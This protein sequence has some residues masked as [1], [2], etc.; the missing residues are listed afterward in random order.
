MNPALYPLPHA[1]RQREIYQN[2]YLEIF[3]YTAFTLFFNWKQS[4]AIVI[5]WLQVDLTLFN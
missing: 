1:A 5:N 2:S 4:R 3:Q